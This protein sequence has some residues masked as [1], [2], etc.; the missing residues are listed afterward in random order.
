MSKKAEIVASNN[1]EELFDMFAG[2]PP[3][4]PFD[5]KK[6]HFAADLAALMVHAGKSRAEMARDLDWPKS[7][8]TSVLSGKNNLT[9][10]TI[11]EFSAGLGYDVDVV[12]RLPSEQPAPQPWARVELVVVNNTETSAFQV[13]LQ[14]AKQV[15][16]DIYNGVERPFYL[17]VGL[18]SPLNLDIYTPQLTNERSSIATQLP[19]AWMCM[20]DSVE[21][22]AK[23]IS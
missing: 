7:R 14:T 23:D 18:A 3:Q 13:E 22:D 2:L 10:K 8:I 17:S 5:V 11:Y 1:E 20:T 15:E 6:D 4:N 21:F 19:S 12:F 9:V 16:R